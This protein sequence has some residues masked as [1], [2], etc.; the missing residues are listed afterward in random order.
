ME[1]T[2]REIK[3]P[4]MA[5]MLGLH[6]ISNTGVRPI[7]P[8]LGSEAGNATK[9]SII[10]ILPDFRI[11]NF[12]PVLDTG[13]SRMLVYTRAGNWLDFHHR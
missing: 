10:I 13:A 6:N 4:L 2:V 3:I 12:F 1:I 8:I 5:I 11:V 7:M 9:P